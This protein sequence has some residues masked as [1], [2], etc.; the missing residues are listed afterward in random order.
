[1]GTHQDPVQ[2]AV[3]GILAVMGTLLN[4]TLDTLVCMAAHSLF[5]LIFVMHLDCPA[6]AKTYISF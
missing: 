3:V 2:G 5:L 1:M 6:A 4:G